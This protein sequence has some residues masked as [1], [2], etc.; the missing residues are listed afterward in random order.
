VKTVDA[1]V[2]RRVRENAVRPTAV[3]LEIN[4]RFFGN[5]S[6]QRGVHGLIISKLASLHGDVH[7]E[8][9]NATGHM[10]YNISDLF[11]NKESHYGEF[12]REFHFTLCK[13]HEIH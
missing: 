10:L 12:V 13:L 3:S 2:L 1:N 7:L 9:Y 5:L 4:G 11:L 8:K 6:Q